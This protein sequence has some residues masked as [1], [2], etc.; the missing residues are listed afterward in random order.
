MTERLPWILVALLGAALLW[1]QMS[2]GK[3]IDELNRTLSGPQTANL[4]D[5]ETGTEAPALL[6]RVQLLETQ[7]A[8]MK[9]H[10]KGRKGRRA[11]L[12]RMGQQLAN[13]SRSPPA[14][15]ASTGSATDSGETVLEVLESDDP[16]VRDRLSDVIDDELSAR[17]ERRWEERRE[18]RAAQAEQMV[19]D[20]SREHR[21][22]AG[23][24]QT[25]RDLLS[26]EQEQISEFFQAARQD[27]SWGEA[28]DKAQDLRE[29]NDAEAMELL[30]DEAYA[31]WQGKRDDEIARHY[32]RRR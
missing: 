26:D 18:R 5:T 7:I 27:H 13:A 16:N 10:R 25:L 8:E 32:G 2:H 30:D 19:T 21:L 20:L 4:A 23:Q 6:A 31:A 17:R 1:M 24:Q 3:Q 22:S 15:M 14:A 29:E 12:G 28:R 9:K 11:G